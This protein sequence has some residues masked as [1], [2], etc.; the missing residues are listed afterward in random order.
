[1]S[2]C[3]GSHLALLIISDIEYNNLYHLPGAMRTKLA[4][5]ELRL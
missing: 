5:E 4:P 1:M 3:E 2:F